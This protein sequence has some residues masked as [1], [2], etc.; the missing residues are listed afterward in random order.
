MIRRPPRSTLFPYTTLFRSQA[1]AVEAP[2]QQDTR[3]EDRVRVE[4]RESAEQGLQPVGMGVRERRENDRGFGEAVRQG[5]PDGLVGVRLLSRGSRHGS[6]GSLGTTARVK[7]S[8][9]L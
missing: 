3:T 9:S 4:R 7:G 5:L 8:R 1:A 2:A 6:L